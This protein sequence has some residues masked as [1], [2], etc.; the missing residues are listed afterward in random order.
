MS[1]NFKPLSLTLSLGALVGSLAMVSAAN[2]SPLFGVVSLGSAGYMAVGEGKCGEGK[3][4]MEKM[5]S[6]KDGMVSKAEHDAAASAMFDAA[7]ANKDGMMSKEEMEK[8]HEG[9]CGEGKCGAEK[10]KEAKCGAEKGKE[11]KCG[12]EKGKEGKCGGAA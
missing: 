1:K 6:N 10:G 8:A 4:G 9:K 3:C 7:D 12:A 11:A 2:A 5:D